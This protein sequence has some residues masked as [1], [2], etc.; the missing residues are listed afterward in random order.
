MV[1]SFGAW[2]DEE[3]IA[4]VADKYIGEIRYVFRKAERYVK[5]STHNEDRGP[6]NSRGEKP[7][8][9]ARQKLRTADKTDLWVEV[10]N[11]RSN[12]REKL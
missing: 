2:C 7:A 5:R 3:R 1:G 8:R 10:E 12:D 9:N 11:A 6:G 4:R